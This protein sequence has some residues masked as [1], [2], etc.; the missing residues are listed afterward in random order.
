MQYPVDEGSDI[1]LPD[2]GIVHV[3][4]VKPSGAAVII[5]VNGARWLI[6]KDSLKKAELCLFATE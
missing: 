3:E 6:G 2:M 5:D 4:E 1:L